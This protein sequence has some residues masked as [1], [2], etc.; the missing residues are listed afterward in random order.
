[1]YYVNKHWATK[2][3]GPKHAVL[4]CSLGSEVN[5]WP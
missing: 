1:M 4:K 2:A 5:C 3:Y